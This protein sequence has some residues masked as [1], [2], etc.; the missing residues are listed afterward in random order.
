M[1]PDQHRG[2]EAASGGSTG[3]SPNCGIQQVR[4]GIFIKDQ[5]LGKGIELDFGMY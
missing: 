3:E 4:R 1:G 5:V 2:E